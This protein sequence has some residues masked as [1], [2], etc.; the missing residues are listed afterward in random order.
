MNLKI[1]V[2]LN[3]RQQRQRREPL[4]P[5]PVGGGSHL[6]SSRREEALTAK[7]EIR[8]PKSRIGMSFLTSA[9]TARWTGRFSSASGIR[10]SAFAPAFTLIELLVVLAVIAI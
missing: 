8:N 7:S 9:A 4:A 1:L 6:C 2:D 10:H 5:N 3:R